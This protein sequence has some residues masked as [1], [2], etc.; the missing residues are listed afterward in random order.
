[1]KALQKSSVF[2]IVQAFELFE[3]KKKKDKFD[4][5]KRDAPHYTWWG[6]CCNGGET[7]SLQ[8]EA[9]E[10]K[11]A[12]IDRE[13]RLAMMRFFLRTSAPRILSA[14]K[15]LEGASSNTGG[16]HEG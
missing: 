14:Q 1:M 9:V 13:T 5:H 4:R 15:E 12:P 11:E 2:L 8:E 10:K 7:M 16:K 3:S 6:A